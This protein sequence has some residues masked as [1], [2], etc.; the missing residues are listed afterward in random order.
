[1]ATRNRM[2]V[3]LSPSRIPELSAL[4]FEQREWVWAQCC[5]PLL[6]RLPIRFAKLAV[7]AP[8]YYYYCMFLGFRT[9]G[10]SIG[11]IIAMAAGIFAGIMALDHLFDMAVVSLNRKTISEFVEHNESKLR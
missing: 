5:Q 1:M 2:K 8:C 9:D 3:F 6:L 4:T 7:L 11:W 10:L